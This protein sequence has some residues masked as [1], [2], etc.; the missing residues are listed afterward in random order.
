MAFGW[1][2]EHFGG[3]LNQKTKLVHVLL[4]HDVEPVFHGV[5]I[6]ATLPCSCAIASCQLLEPRMLKKGNETELEELK[7][8]LTV[9]TYLFLLFIRND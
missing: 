6:V 9:T 2:K 1:R 5:C 4:G 8:C 7:H 3:A